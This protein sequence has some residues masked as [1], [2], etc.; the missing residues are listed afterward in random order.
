[1]RQNLSMVHIKIVP[2]NKDVCISCMKVNEDISLFLKKEKNVQSLS[3]SNK[4][5]NS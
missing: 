1:M 3:G 2:P 4:K 5:Y